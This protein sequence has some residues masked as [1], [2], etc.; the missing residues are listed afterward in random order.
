MGGFLTFVVIAAGVIWLLWVWRKREMEKFREGDLRTL[1]ELTSDERLRD[2]AGD[3]RPANPVP[4]ADAVSTLPSTPSAISTLSMPIPVAEPTGASLKPAVLDEIHASVL[5]L[6]EE[7]AEESAMG[8][9]GDRYR[10]LARKPLADVVRLDRVEALGREVSFV[11]CERT[12]FKPV[13]AIALKG[14][15][16]AEAAKFDY[17]RQV[18]TE[19]GLPFAGF[20][21]MANLSRHELEEGIRPLLA[22]S[23]PPP[24]PE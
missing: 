14:A 4:P 19:V 1:R 20:P 24:G 2:A 22:P 15:G 9:A 11:V 17:V 18:C 3:Q 12:T 13:A 6:I 7:I 5:P 21:M 10:V 23:P 16:P 8:S